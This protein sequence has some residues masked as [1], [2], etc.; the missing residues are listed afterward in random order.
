MK[1]PEGRWR[2]M[3]L[4]TLGIVVEALRDVNSPE[5]AEID[6]FLPKMKSQLGLQEGQPGNVEH[7]IQ[8]VQKTVSK[9]LPAAGCSRWFYGCDA[10]K[11]LTRR[12]AV[13]GFVNDLT[14]KLNNGSP[15]ALDHSS[16]ETLPLAGVH[17]NVHN[18]LFAGSHLLKEQSCSRC[19]RCL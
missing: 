10:S 18:S 9:K 16:L 12:P 14:I 11:F 2:A 19:L 3:K 8:L 1:G 4:N 15:D 13:L 17:G 7:I 6:K 5:R